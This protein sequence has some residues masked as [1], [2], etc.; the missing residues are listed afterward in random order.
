M[1]IYV[2]GPCFES[3]RR[4]Y[5]PLF[6]QD[7]RGVPSFESGFD[8][9]LNV[10][11]LGK[12]GVLTT[13]DDF[14]IAYLSGYQSFKSTDYTFNEADIEIL[15]ETCSISRIDILMTTSYPLN[16]DS[17]SF[18]VKTDYLKHLCQTG[19]ILVSKLAKSVLPR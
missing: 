12:K 1:P 6:D 15:I 13:T 8:I 17:H 3:Q 2:L 9:A 4:F 16:V 11:Y 19:S 10:N 18:T 5:K 14:K 7:L